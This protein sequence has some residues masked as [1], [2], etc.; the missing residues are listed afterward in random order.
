VYVVIAMSGE[1]GEVIVTFEG[2]VMFFIPL[3]EIS[4]R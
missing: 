2:L 3:W 1:F 4:D